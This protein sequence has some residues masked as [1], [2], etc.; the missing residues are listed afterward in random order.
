MAQPLLNSLIGRRLLLRFVLAALLPMG[1][2]A[3][4]AYF[5]VGDMMTELNYH[6]LQQDSRSLGMRFVENLNWRAHSLQQEAARLSQPG[7][8]ANPRLEGFLHH[9]VV[10]NPS[11]LE[12]TREQL[13]HL[14]QGATLLFLTGKL[15][16]AMLTVMPNA[17]RLLLGQMDRQTLWRDDEAPEHYC[18][19]NADFQPFYCTPDLAP[20]SA[21][22]WPRLLAQ[23]NGRVFPWLV[24]EDGSDG[25]YLAAF[26]QARLQASYAHPGI[27][28]MVADSKQAVLKGVER[29]QQIFPA[30]IV[31]ALALAVLLAIN[32]IRRQM[33]PLE[34]LMEGTRRLANG[35]LG[36][37]VQGAGE[38]EFGRL[39]HAF[40]R[41]SGNLQSKF[42]MLQMLA[43]L[44]R[45]ILGA[46]EMDY[47]VQSVL[48][49]IRQAIPCDSAGLIRGGADGNEM[50][51]A[52]PGETGKVLGTRSCSGIRERLSQDAEQPWL[53]LQLDAPPADCLQPLFE[54]PLKEVLLFPS[55]VNGRLD[56]LLILAFE[57]LPESISDI[58]PAGLSVADRLAVASSNLAWGEKLY[59]QAHYDALTDLPNRVLLRDRVEQALVRAGRERTSVALLLLD[60]DNFKQVNDS[61]GH[62]AGD[63]L[64]IECAHRLKSHIRQS[65]TVARLSGDEF[66]ILVP[67]LARGSESGML[68][69]LARKLNEML[70]IPVLISGR[71][72]TTS[73]SIGISIYP[74]NAENFEDLL[75]MAD[76]AM[77]EA[78][79]KQPG[80]FRFY[81]ANMNEKAQARFELEQDL[82]EAINRQEFLLYY[83]PKFELASRRIIGAEALVRWNCPKRGLVAPGLFVHLLDEMGLADWLSNWVLETACA[84]MAAWDR[85]GLPALSVSVNISPRQF[86]FGNLLERVRGA[87]DGNGL[88]PQR[89]E[90]EILETT[91]VNHS[92]EVR[93]TLASLREMN[94]N[95]ALDD[96]G[97]GYSSLVYLT[98]VPANILKID[99]AFIQNLVAD[100]RQQAIVE[101]IIALAK[102]LDFCV[103]AEGVDEAAQMDLLAAM[104]CD[105][106]QGYLISR[107]LPPDD[108][109]QQLQS[110][111]PGKALMQ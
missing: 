6:R 27:I 25:D 85:L 80:G 11:Q 74:D 78:K 41:M 101:R 58:V 100:T 57:K 29:F 67:D 42:H 17:Q 37:T 39:A 94:V 97:T 9:S 103:V 55:R 1:G 51:M 61:L 110:H 111:Y 12:L 28:V 71:Q 84:Q 88:A 76:A 26:W 2:V 23:R 22:A 68:E 38:D 44:D 60:L 63:A 54:A 75:K 56:T 66:I 5:Q 96:F 83:Q 24:R 108:F 109:V 45:A 64:L 14:A 99:R 36:A 52:T 90:L 59:H 105:V 40:N 16:P 33:R 62:V 65:D 31:A 50:F 95:I 19:V 69:T 81:S 53:H 20:P 32:Q 86:Q 93:D 107:P 92:A 30:L 46:S 48:R 79:Q 7:A 3:L 106:I 4:I 21:E 10:E 102:V 77:Y 43:E 91:A 98:L 87:L 104:H 73:V 89:L 15:A 72:V 82:R 35:E 8:T 13:H 34:L 49:Q 70:A 47:L 18:V